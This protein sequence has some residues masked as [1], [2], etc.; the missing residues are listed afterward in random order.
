MSILEEKEVCEAG[1]SVEDAIQY[2]TEILST[3]LV[4]FKVTACF[5]DGCHSTS[6]SLV[7]VAK[8]IVTLHLSGRE[9]EGEHLARRVVLGMAGIE[10][11]SLIEDFYN[12][13]DAMIGQGRAYLQNACSSPSFMHG[14]AGV[15]CQD[16][17]EVA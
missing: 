2:A 10:T 1:N 4:R 16:A 9:D 5:R 7:D 3:E 13:L 15:E 6:A 11:M 8:R 12:L 17:E 14:G